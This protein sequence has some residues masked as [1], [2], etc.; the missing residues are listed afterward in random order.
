[1]V[2]QGTIEEHLLKLLLEKVRLF[3]VVIGNLQKIITCFGKEKSFESRIMGALVAAETE[4][5]LTRNLE[6]LGAEI[7]EKLESPPALTIDTLL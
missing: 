4:A 7:L 5:E 6:I 1:M 2:T 3:E